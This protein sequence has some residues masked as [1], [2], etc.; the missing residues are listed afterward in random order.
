VFLRFEVVH[1]PERIDGPGL[2]DA[3]GPRVRLDVADGPKAAVVCSSMNSVKDDEAGD[4]S[5]DHVQRRG[6]GERVTA[7]CR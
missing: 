6:D 3:V 2:R 4:M 5:A 7:S 1:N